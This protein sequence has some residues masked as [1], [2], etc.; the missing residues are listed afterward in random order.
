MRPSFHIIILI[1]T[2]AVVAE[3]RSVAISVDKHIVA[4]GET[5]EVTVNIKSS[6]QRGYD[7]YHPPGFANFQVVGNMR[8][9][10]LEI[11]NGN[12]KSNEI[13]SYTVVPQK[14]GKLK[15]G[16]AVIVVRGQKYSS[17]II[18]IQVKKSS[19][20]PSNNNKQ[21]F[22]KQ[23]KLSPVFISADAD[24]DTVYVGQQTTVSW[25]IYTQISVPD[26]G[27]TKK[28]TVDD[29]LL[30]ELEPDGN[31]E[32][33]TIKGVRYATGEIYRVALFPEKP[34]KLTIGPLQ[35]RYGIWSSKTVVSNSLTVDVL[36]LPGQ[37]QPPGFFPHNVGDFDI[38]ASASRRRVK[39][40]EGVTY[41]IVV[42]GNGNLR[43]LQ[44]PKIENIKG[45]KVYDPKIQENY[46]SAVKFGG[47]KIYE[48][49]LVPQESGEL[50]IPP[51]KLDYFNT[52]KKEYAAVQ[53][54]KIV[55]NV[56]GKITS[57]N[58]LTTTQTKKN[59][60]GLTIRPPRTDP[61][62]VFKEEKNKNINPIFYLLF[63]FPLLAYAV[64]IISEKVRS[65]LKKETPASLRRAAF[66]KC[67]AQL[68][69]ANSYIS[70]SVFFI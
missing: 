47:E 52:R 28:P 40:G 33:Q 59:I 51:V 41:K 53:T 62:I 37:K 31:Q 56:I 43:Y 4:L 19:Q 8:S 50:I 7:N 35:A 58:A 30:E 25:R 24:L 21:P 69:K 5:V 13:H 39:A 54:N 17:S 67:K 22:L 63:F 65:G 29:F 61:N 44:L 18:T 70:S 64:L 57:E 12:V 49:L 1:L 10:N 26:F 14:E 46:Q 45:F 23:Q 6:G 55:I 20:Q 27:I 60:I 38:L 68:Q 42:K 9:Q 34:G 2:Y 16:P 66:R 36:P 15:I 32:Y 11:I 3:S 48:Y